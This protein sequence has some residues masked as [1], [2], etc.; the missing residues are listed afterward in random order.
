MNYEKLMKS[1]LESYKTAKL[2]LSGPETWRGKG[3]YHYILPVDRQELNFLEPYRM[4]TSGQVADKKIKLHQFF[5][6]LNSSQAVC[7]NFFYPLILEG[8]LPIVLKILQLGD[9]PVKHWAFEKIM[10][11]GERTNFD[12]YMELKSGKEILFEIKYTENGFGKVTAGEKHDTRYRNVYQNMLAG[13][14]RPGIEACEAMAKNYQLLRNIAYV[15]PE[16][17]RQLLF[18]CPANNKKLHVEYQNVMDN[19]V[20]P[21]LHVN[22]R[23]VTWESLLE[24]LKE[25]L[26]IQ[27][28]V[29]AK[30]KDHY[31]EFEEKYFPA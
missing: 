15:E 10:P 5:H 1:H 28:N 20:E 31:R 25:Q 26:E 8:Q 21:A 11:G 13:K 23:M 4:E 3:T 18:I 7:L 19:I 17:N 22:I 14:I 16:K 12:F 30:L 6:H 9:E 27:P 2:G 29:P 24:R